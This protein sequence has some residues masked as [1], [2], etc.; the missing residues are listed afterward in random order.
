MGNI[1][2]KKFYKQRSDFEASMPER[3]QKFTFPEGVKCTE[4]IA[5]MDD[6]GAPA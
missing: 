3:E 4:N 6:S 2:I 5:Y 1:M